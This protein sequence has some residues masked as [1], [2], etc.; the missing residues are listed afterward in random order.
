ML[1]LAYLF[2]VGVLGVFTIGY[3]TPKV[4]IWGSITTGVIWMTAHLIPAFTPNEVLSTMGPRL[5]DIFFVYPRAMGLAF[6]ART[7]ADGILGG[8][9]VIIIA[10]LWL[11]PYIAGLILGVTTW[12]E[13][14]VFR[15][16]L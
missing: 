13:L 9:A 15:L 2:I 1:E 3:V 7:A 4:A 5:L 14:F 11:I 8:M 12:P 10:I 6:E 16:F